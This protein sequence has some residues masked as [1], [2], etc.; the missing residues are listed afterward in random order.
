VGYVAQGG[1]GVGER[2]KR[3][4][5]GEEAGPILVA[6]VRHPKA[7]NP[8]KSQSPSDDQRTATARRKEGRMA[9]RAQ[10]KPAPSVEQLLATL[11]AHL[12]ELQERYGVRTL[13]VFGSYVRGK[14]KKRT[15]LDL[16]VEFD[17]RPLSLLAFIGLEH[18]LSDLLGVKVDLVEKSG[19]KPAIGRHILEEVRPV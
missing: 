11:R 3:A 4:G 13:G 2:Q 17:D 14:A 1:S 9:T 8:S 5:E 6:G 19:L 16:L 7:E 12:P 10:S 18:Y 15:D